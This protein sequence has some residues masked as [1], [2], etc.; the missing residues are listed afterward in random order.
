MNVIEELIERGEKFHA[1]ED[2]L[3]VAQAVLTYAEELRAATRPEQFMPPRSK[4][5]YG[6]VA[7]ELAVGVA[8]GS[9]LDC[10]FQF[11]DEDG[12]TVPL[13]EAEQFTVR[14]PYGIDPRIRISRAQME[15]YEKEGE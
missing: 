9:P 11:V 6:A 10:W 14:I 1:E 7:V 15:A 3:R 8:A 12:C 2:D 4:W 13:E 5:P